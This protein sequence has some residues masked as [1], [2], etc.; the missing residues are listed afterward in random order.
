MLK[1]G[2]DKEKMKKEEQGNM[3]RTWGTSLL[4]YGAGLLPC[5]LLW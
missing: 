5:V 2:R 4:G 3:V 1:V